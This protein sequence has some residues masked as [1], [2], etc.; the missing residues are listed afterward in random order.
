MLHLSSQFLPVQSHCASHK[1][2]FNA[3]ANPRHA[4]NIH[5]ELLTNFP[6][7]VF[8]PRHTNLPSKFQRNLT[9]FAS[10]TNI[11]AT[12]FQ[13]REKNA[14]GCL[15]CHNFFSSFLYDIENTPVSVETSQRT[16]DCGKESNFNIDCIFN[17]HYPPHHPSIHLLAT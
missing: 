3:P 4:I 13:S 16:L 6:E 2:H 5:P 1:M 15:L 17:C 7:T 8:R 11:Q 12:N 14:Q 10:A 9:P